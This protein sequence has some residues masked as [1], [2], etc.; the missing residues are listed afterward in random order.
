M[1]G[2]P[3]AALRPPHA[4]PAVQVPAL[5]VP[6]HGWPIP[7]HA[8]HML[9]VAETVHASVVPHA[10]VFPVAPPTAQQV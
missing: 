8:A 3:A 5:P 9:P 4:R 6:Q 1:P 7:P 10:M 2:V